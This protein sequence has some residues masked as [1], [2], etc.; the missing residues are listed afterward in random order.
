MRYL[1]ICGIFICEEPE[2]LF[3]F[4]NFIS[5]KALYLLL[6]RDDLN[7]NEIEIWKFIEMVFCST[8]HEK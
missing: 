4:D 5:L 3:N 8:K 2:I 1:Q 7:M 6:K